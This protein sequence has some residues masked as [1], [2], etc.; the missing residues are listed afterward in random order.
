[1]SDTS[2]LHRERHCT[3]KIAYATK[4]DAN[5]RLVWHK[6]RDGRSNPGPKRDKLMAYKCTY[7]ESWHVGHKPITRAR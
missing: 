3:S 6:H 5:K 1:M 7:C 2:P 4:R